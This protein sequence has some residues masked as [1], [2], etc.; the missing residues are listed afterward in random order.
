M[1]S[2]D[3]LDQVLKQWAVQ[4]DA[5]DDQHQR[6][7][8]RICETLRQPL[9]VSRRKPVGAVR[10]I[11]GSG[12]ALAVLMGLSFWFFSR[13]ERTSRFENS[14]NGRP[15]PIVRSDYPDS[16]VLSKDFVA[17][18]TQLLV[19]MNAV[20]DHQLVWIVDGPRDVSVRVANQ[21][22]DERD[23]FVLVRMVVAQRRT[24]N[25]AWSLIWQTD[26]IARVDA[27]VEFDARQSPGAMTLW[28]H[29]MPDN[30]YNIDMDLNDMQRSLLAS[31]GVVLKVGQPKQVASSRV[32]GIERCVFQT[33]VPL[34][35][36]I[37]PS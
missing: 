26:V 16:A 17:A 10:L 28:T 33:V 11:V 14:S 34:N 35:P 37:V 9:L 24:P 30:E 23:E 32:D 36:V 19:E 21:R 4:R 2:D 8:A 15:A 13:F 20:F 22:L 6:L 25:D 27:V 7:A 18:K 29:A 5:T 1:N 31:T 3:R 12:C